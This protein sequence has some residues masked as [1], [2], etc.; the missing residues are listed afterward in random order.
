MSLMRFDDPNRAISDTVKCES[1]SRLIAVC[2]C[3]AYKS[4][5]KF[6]PILLPHDRVVGGVGGLYPIA[7]TKQK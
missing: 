1:L 3:V 4:H 7:R 5:C 2:H 6:P